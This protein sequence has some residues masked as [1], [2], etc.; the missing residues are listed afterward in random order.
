M[1]VS[2]VSA[3]RARAECDNVIDGNKRTSKRNISASTSHKSPLSAAKTCIILSATPSFDVVFYGPTMPHELCSMY[4]KISEFFVLIVLL[5]VSRTSKKLAM[6]AG[7]L[8]L[9]TA[10]SGHF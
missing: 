9:H 10:H 3:W 1:L 4:N 5:C 2:S 8:I 7:K 6:H